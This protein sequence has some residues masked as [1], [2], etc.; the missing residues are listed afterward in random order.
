VAAAYFERGDTGHA[1][2]L[3]KQTIARAEELNSPTARGSAY[4]NASMMASRQGSVQEALAMAQKAIS[5]FELE[6]DTRNLARLRTELAHMQL[7][8]DP[9]AAAEAKRTLDLASRE[10]DWS[11]ASAVDKADHQLALA[12]A[13]LLLGDPETAA[14]L[15]AS[16]YEL[17]RDQAPITVAEVLVL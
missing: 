12:R 14:D 15:A 8:Q 1:V 10:L 2:R 17:A 7:R 3:C 11:S 9:P 5:V 6:S 16:S 4:W 13:T